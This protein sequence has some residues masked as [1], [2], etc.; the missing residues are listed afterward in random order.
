MMTT[1]NNYRRGRRLE[2]LAR[3]ALVAEGYTVIRAAGSKGPV[4]LVAMNAN[5]VRL[6]Q[7]KS[8]GHVQEGDREKLRAVKCPH[9]QREIWVRYP[10]EWRIEIVRP[11]D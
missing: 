6:V 11:T 7:I 3:A 1:S 4:D 9:A 8:P 10:K 5:Q 2:Y